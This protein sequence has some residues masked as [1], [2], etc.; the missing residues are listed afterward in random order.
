MK[1][2]FPK[3]KQFDKIIKNF[4]NNFELKEHS[5]GKYYRTYRIH[6]DDFGFIE[7]H[8]YEVVKGDI[9]VKVFDKMISL[10]FEID[11]RIS[12][13]ENKRIHF[14]LYNKIMRY[15]VRKLIEHELIDVESYL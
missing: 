8:M 9:F 11:N 12:D 4:K 6:F 1:K 7:N 2:K 3:K 5:F 14:E 13:D 10:D 15:F